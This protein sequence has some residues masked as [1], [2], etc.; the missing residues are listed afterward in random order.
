M[1]LI[2]PSC[3]TDQGVQHIREC[4]GVKP[5]REMKVNGGGIRKVHHRPVRNDFMKDL[6][7]SVFVGTRKM[8]A[9]AT[10]KAKFL[11]KVQHRG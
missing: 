11:G 6:S 8:L 5:E 4:L 10:L 3:N 1:V 2:D 7:K 9:V